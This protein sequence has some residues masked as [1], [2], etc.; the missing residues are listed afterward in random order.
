MGKTGK[1]ETVAVVVNM[2][3]EL[4]FTLKKLALMHGISLS[5]LFRAVLK[6]YAEQNADKLRRYDE[7]VSGSTLED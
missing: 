6:D 7:L 2:D 3:P 1:A 4:K 5:K